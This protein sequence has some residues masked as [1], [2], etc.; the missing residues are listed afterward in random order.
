MTCNECQPL[1]SHAFRSVDDLIHAIRLA[2]E[3]VDRGVLERDEDRERDSVEGEA[4]DSSLATGALPAH[5]CLRFRCRVCGDR[6]LLEADTSD[7]QGA[8]TREE[9]PVS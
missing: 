5:L 2:A 6:F 1:S 9:D 7:G 3:E 4:I 8:W